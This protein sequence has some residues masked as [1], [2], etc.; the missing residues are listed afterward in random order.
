MTSVLS[1]YSILLQGLID[2]ERPNVGV[3]SVSLNTC[4]VADPGD[5]KSTTM[6]YL[7][8]P[9]TDHFDARRAYCEEAMAVYEV[10]MEIYRKRRKVLIK[11]LTDCDSKVEDM[12][13]LREELYDLERS[14]PCKPTSGIILLEDATPEA[15]ASALAEGSASVA[16]V[17]PEGGSILGGRIAQ[18][19]P[20]LNKLWSGESWTVNRKTSESFVVPDG[21]LAV[22]IMVQPKALE[23]FM[24]NRGEES[25]GIGFLGRFIVCNPVSTQGSRLI[26]Y[27]DNFNDYYYQE[28]LAAAEAI[29]DAVEARSRYKSARKVMH[30]SAQASTNWIYLFNYIETQLNLT[31]RFAF[32]RDHGSKL[33]EIIARI[34]A[35]LAYIEEGG[36]CEISAGILQ[37]ATSVGFYFSDTFLRLFSVLPDHVIHDGILREYLQTKREGGERYIKKNHIRQSG[38]SVLRSKVILDGC[39]HRLA[40]SGEIA[41]LVTEA[42][43]HVID[44]YPSMPPDGDRWHKDIILKYGQ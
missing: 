32:A 9:F 12:T 4:G 14:K 41:I 18:N 11:K 38:P 3:G 5:R 39:L 33:A 10:D 40:H 24:D 1:T 23:K 28:Y 15:L 35:L 17:S 37:D 16:L 42:N 34:A 25:R 36:V 8:K 21:R 22:S 2:V 29:L 30:F 20:M 13:V 44:L 26:H 27:A 31:G 43:M 19:L 6:K 7:N